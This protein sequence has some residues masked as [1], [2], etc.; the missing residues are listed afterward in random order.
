MCP[1]QKLVKQNQKN[2][3]KNNKEKLKEQARCSYENL[4]E[5]EKYPK[6]QKDIKI[7]PKAIK[8]KRIWKN[9]L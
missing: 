6:K 2:I 1:I 3:I 5:K 7:Y 4:S 9:A 8:T